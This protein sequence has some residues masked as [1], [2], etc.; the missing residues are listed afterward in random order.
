[1]DILLKIAL[2]REDLT[3]V[4]WKGKTLRF[5]SV[6]RHMQDKLC[7]KYKITRLLMQH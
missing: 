7:Q 1:M 3:T 2:N 4:W 6:S 5:A